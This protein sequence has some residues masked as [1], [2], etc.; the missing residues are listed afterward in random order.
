MLLQRQVD[1][2]RYTAQYHNARTK[3]STMLN[4]FVAKKIHNV[5]FKSNIKD[6]WDMYFFNFGKKKR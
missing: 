4:S 5:L 3:V 1:R 6:A 2:Q